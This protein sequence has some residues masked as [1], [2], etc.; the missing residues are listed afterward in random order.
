[1]NEKSVT[2]YELILENCET[3]ILS[4]TDL[5]E[6]NF[7][8]LDKHIDIWQEENQVLRKEALVAKDALLIFDA[9]SLRARR[10]SFSNG[11]YNAY[12]RVT[13]HSDIV[14]L[15]IFYS[16]NSNELI[17]VP[18]EGDYENKLQETTLEEVQGK[19]R[20]EIYFGKNVQEISATV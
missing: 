14:A 5:I 10:P 12:E 6:A 18:F 3:I 9:E 20:L 8:G 16:D 2:S 4:A 1:M 13:K 7:A 15:E 17:Y 19:E 11:E